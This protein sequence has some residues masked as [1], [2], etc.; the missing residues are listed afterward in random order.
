MQILF[1]NS[2][3]LRG[4]LGVNAEIHRA[5][6]KLSRF[7]ADGGERAVNRAKA[8]ERSME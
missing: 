8:R 4:F 3:T 1:S 7:C 6:I 2:L 5:D